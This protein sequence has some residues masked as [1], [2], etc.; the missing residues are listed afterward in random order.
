V[1][2]GWGGPGSGTN[3]VCRGRRRAEVAV[4]AGLTF[5]VAWSFGL[6]FIVLALSSAAAILARQRFLARR[7][8]PARLAAWAV[9]APC[10]PSTPVALE[11]AMAVDLAA[12]SGGYLDCLARTQRMLALSVGDPWRRGLGEE[13]L[14]RAGRLVADGAFVGIRSQ[15]DSSVARLRRAG[16]A[17]ALIVLPA[18]ATLSQSRWWLVPMAVVHAL[19][20]CEFAALYERRWALPELLASRS[21]RN[22]VEDLF[23]MSAE[24]V[25]RSLVALANNDA[26]VIQRA[27]CMLERRDGHHNARRRLAEAER[28]LVRDD[29]N[30][31]GARLTA[32]ALAVAI[33]ST[34]V[35]TTLGWGIW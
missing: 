34:A 26:L 35:S 9:H 4:V 23:V 15:S 18:P 28:L 8:L 10:G 30:T 7:G 16:A 13:R 24:D 21:L 22:P 32:W 27:R 14:E 20:A 6:W 5:A 31:P 29:G 19:L 17:V 2:K 12:V 3:A 33:P 1:S 11:H 25:A